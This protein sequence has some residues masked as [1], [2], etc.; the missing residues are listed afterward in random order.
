VAEG[1]E[2]LAE[3]KDGISSPAKAMRSSLKVLTDEMKS[4]E[5]EI[6]KLQAIQLQYQ[7]A[8]Q[9][10]HARD[11]GQSIA[12]LRQQ[13]RGLSMDM[14]DLT[15]STSKT[16]RAE[17]EAASAAAAAAAATKAAAAGNLSV[18]E[19]GVE[20]L[21]GEAVVVGGLVAAWGA[22]SL[23]VGGA[24]LAGSEFALEASQFRKNMTEAFGLF[25]DSKEAG[26]ETYA[27]VRNISAALHAP[28]EK[29]GALTQELLV[30]GMDNQARLTETVKAVTSLARVGQEAGAEKLRG[31][32][33]KAIAG[34]DFKVSERQLKGTGIKLPELLATLAK[35]THKSIDEVKAELKNG[36][37][38]VG[39][40]ID[41]INKT[42]NEGKIGQLA[43]GKVEVGDALVDFKNYLQ[44]L[45][46]DIPGVEEF[47][48]DAREFAGIFSDDTASGMALHA[49][50]KQLFGFLL[51]EGADALTSLKHGFLYAELFA[52][53]AEHAVYPFTS[54]LG[55]LKAVASDVL[56]VMKGIAIVGGS[57]FGVSEAYLGYKAVKS[58]V[59]QYG[60]GPAEAAAGVKP[61]D[62]SKPYYATNEDLTGGVAKA[63]A[64]AQGGLVGPADGEG[65]AS[66]AP[67]EMIL[68]RDVVAGNDNGAPG[69]G[70]GAVTHHVEVHVG[71][72]TVHGAKDGDHAIELMEDDIADIFERAAAEMGA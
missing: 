22:V 50:N 26:E 14:R 41:A 31:I 71:G 8:G 27:S 40:G 68:P 21:G 70:S 62:T 15:A 38:D 46:T 20:A 47:A 33:E 17:A 37:I 29:V 36:G 24:V 6:F 7:Q 4:T 12:G 56:G 59:G 55:G 30:A 61:Q 58:L 69:G 28:I 65:F 23:A 18:L 52:L 13:H 60:T 25:L 1:F 3:I 43:L 10:K 54:A 66:V 51:H 42:I 63:P 48:R 9:V 32:V 19:H 45:F 34:G 67:G 44:N 39:L 49:T 16:T 5:R 53:K 2:W 11:V 35:Q 64:H 57:L 72:I